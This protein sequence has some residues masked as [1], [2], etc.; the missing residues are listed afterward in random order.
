MNPSLQ[1]GFHEP[2]SGSAKKLEQFI[3]RNDRLSTA[4]TKGFLEGLEN[5]RPFGTRF[6]VRYVIIGG[7]LVGL[8]I[9]V[10]FMDD[11][12]LRRLYPDLSK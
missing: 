6:D 9:A 5:D 4:K 8:I 3:T 1:N 11:N 12:D 10:T 7:I 2:E